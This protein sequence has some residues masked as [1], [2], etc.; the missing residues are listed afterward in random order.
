[1][2]KN[3][4]N[5]TKLIKDTYDAGYGGILFPRGYYSFCSTYYPS[6]NSESE[7]IWILNIAN[8]I[9]DFN[10]STL[11]F[12]TDSNA[13]W[14]LSSLGLNSSNFGADLDE[15]GTITYSNKQFKRIATNESNQSQD[16]FCEINESI[17]LKKDEEGK[18]YV[19]TTNTEDVY[20]QVSGYNDF[21]IK[22]KGY[23]NRHCKGNLIG[24]K[25]SNNIT[26]RNGILKGDGYSRTFSDDVTERILQ[27]KVQESSGICCNGMF[28][29]NIHLD[30]LDISGFSSDGITTNSRILYRYSS[31]PTY[32]ER[33]SI[34]R[35]Y[36]SEV[37]RYTVYAL[38]RFDKY[39]ILDT[40]DD[41]HSTRFKSQKGPKYRV[42]L[43]GIEN[44]KKQR[45]VGEKIE[46]IF[47]LRKETVDGMP[48]VFKDSYNRKIYTILTIGGKTRD[49]NCYP[50]MEIVTY[51]SLSKNE[52]AAIAGIN[53]NDNDEIDDKTI[54]E[55]FNPENP[56]SGTVYGYFES[57]TTETKGGTTVPKYIT[58]YRRATEGTF[59]MLLECLV[60]QT[61]VSQTN[62]QTGVTTIKTVQDVKYYQ[63]LRILDSEYRED[64]VF[65]ENE[66]HFRPQCHYV[67]VDSNGVFKPTTASG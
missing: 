39:Y 30:H 40:V 36:V 33:K 66:T 27:L 2:R 34:K 56:P 13:N 57:G 28:V 19:K 49:V 23:L 43:D 55:W 51:K 32:S 61:L 62:T 20:R 65:N 5:I 25:Q 24:I 59:E 10:G 15:G 1:M 37:S 60:T 64:I 45:A 63:P 4:E 52:V 8:F 12:Q 29:Y 41:E 16:A 44:D 17:I 21:V 35:D 48:S 38:K 14:D 42:T 3:A 26:I 9:V 31:A 6:N 22:A 47:S 11:E 7:C 67:N 18:L 54:L 58:Y 53:A 50:K 46:T